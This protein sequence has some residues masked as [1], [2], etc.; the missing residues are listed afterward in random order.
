M[1][2]HAHMRV[3]ARFSLIHHIL[4]DIL[5]LLVLVLSEELVMIFI[6]QYLITKKDRCAY[7]HV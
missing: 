3:D 4:S 5:T 6:E 2:A 7:N 1:H